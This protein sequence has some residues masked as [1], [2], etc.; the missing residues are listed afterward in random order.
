MIAR[1]H[2]VSLHRDISSKWHFEHY[3]IY[4]NLRDVNKK[5]HCKIHH[6]FYFG[7]IYISW[8]FPGGTNSKE[9]TCQGR[10]HKTLELDPW[11]GKIL[12]QRAWHPTPVSLPGES[13]AQGILVATVHGVTTWLKSD[14]AEATEHEYTVPRA[15]Q[16]PFYWSTFYLYEFD[17]FRY[18]T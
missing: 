18:I 17:S 5:Q 15:W 12:W 8:G 6:F 9:P 4:L 1:S 3:T 10:R 11:V 2:Y 7:K 13:H 16:P 14:V